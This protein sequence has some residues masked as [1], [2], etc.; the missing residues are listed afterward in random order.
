[1]TNATFRFLI[2]LLPAVLL[3]SS[4]SAQVGLSVFRNF[5]Q[6]TLSYDNG[7]ALEH[8]LDYADGTEVALNYWFR[9]PK[10]RIEFLP[11][12]YYALNESTQDWK[13]YGFQFKTNIY[14]F[15]LATDCDCPTFGKQGPQLEKGFFLQVA[16]G[17][18]RH[19]L[20][21]LDGAYSGSS[22]TASLAG[23]IGLDF[24]L[25][26]LLT[27]TPLAGVRYHFSDFDGV[28]IPDAEGGAATSESRLLTYQLGIQA[29]FR[30]DKRRY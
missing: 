11:T 20:A 30:L 18:S 29:T 8:P 1:M 17:I 25:S 24:G 14:V 15:D 26:N 5:N 4:L 13:T 21:T 7:P 22:T 10:Q 27:I 12:V 3:T 6:A 28:D 19:T 16:P 2:L 9:L 23:G